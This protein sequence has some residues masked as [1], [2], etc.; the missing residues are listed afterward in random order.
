M[1]RFVQWRGVG[2]TAGPA[3][4][5]VV[6]QGGWHCGTYARRSLEGGIKGRGAGAAGAGAGD[7]GKGVG[8]GG[9]CAM[10]SWVL[11]RHSFCVSS[12]LEVVGWYILGLVGSTT[13]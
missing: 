11:A 1:E 8:I 12:A 7:K 2:G 6:E 4:V 13:R 10:G 5:S 3:G 9:A